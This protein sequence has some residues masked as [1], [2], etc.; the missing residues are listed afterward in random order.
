MSKLVKDEAPNNDEAAIIDP[1]KYD[2]FN[3]TNTYKIG[4]L[5]ELLS[6]LVQLFY[7]I[8]KINNNKN[9]TSNRGYLLNKCIVNCSFYIK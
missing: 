2:F 8:T 5:K 9:A 4:F 1:I 7:L 6:L 3:V